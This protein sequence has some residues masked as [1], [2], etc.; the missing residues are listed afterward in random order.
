MVNVL[1]KL[2]EKMKTFDTQI[3]VIFNFQFANGLNQKIETW[4]KGA[5][6]IS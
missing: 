3:L 4:C 6:D 2:E 5:A 1:N